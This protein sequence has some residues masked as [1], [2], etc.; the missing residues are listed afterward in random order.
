MCVDLVLC[1]LLAL[2]SVELCRTELIC[3]GG[4]LSVCDVRVC[5]GSYRIVTLRFVSLALRWCFS[6][7]RCWMIRLSDVGVW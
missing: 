1:V 4:C 2:D 7:S 3:F 6:C 5:S